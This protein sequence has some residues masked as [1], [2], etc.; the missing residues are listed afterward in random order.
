MPRSR[1]V[2][3][4]LDGVLRRFD[5]A[6][7][8]GVEERFGLAPGSLRRHAFDPA[9]A[10]D[11]VRGVVSR[12]VWI[13][14]AGAALGHVEAMRAFLGLRGEVDEE[15]LAVAREVRAA[16]AR[17]GLL[18]NATDSLREE[19]AH[20]G[21]AGEL[22]AVFASCALGCCK[23]EPAVYARVTSELGVRPAEI[24]FVDDQ[25]SNVAGARAAGW[26]AHPFRGAPGLR[27]WLA[28]EGL[29]P[30]AGG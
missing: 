25:A 22:D 8:R 27:A 19:L 7:E 30:A 29:T 1:V 5:D 28:S 18:T 11:A 23:P 17:V 12:S 9:V 10:D 26:R 13:E 4:D 2:L 21:L 15:V 20:L 14:R 3:F 24:A 16:G 6:A